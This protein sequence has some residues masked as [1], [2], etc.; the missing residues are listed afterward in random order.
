MRTGQNLYFHLNHPIKWIRLVGVVV[1]L[2]VHPARW[3]ILLDD[4]SGATIEVICGLQAPAPAIGGR[5]PDLLLSAD[6]R[7]AV[8]SPALSPVGL[9]ATGRTVDLSGVD[10]GAVVKVKGGVGMFRGQKQVL[11]E[12]IC[13]ISFLF[14]PRLFSDLLQHF[15]PACY[16]TLFL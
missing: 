2:D 4:G 9:T 5:E 7:A 16:S 13:T 12:R 15:Y 10:I 6:N 14:I 3:I 1:A 11:L 8:T